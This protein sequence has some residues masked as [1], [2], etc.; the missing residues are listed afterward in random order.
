[1][2]TLHGTRLH[3]GRFT[4][5]IQYGR[6]TFTIDILP[7][8][9]NGRLVTLRQNRLLKMVVGQTTFKH[10]SYQESKSSK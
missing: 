8:V 1:M 2:G 7:D 6:V 10:I 4:D 3:I 9:M 5:K